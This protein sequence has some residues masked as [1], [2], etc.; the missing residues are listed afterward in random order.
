MKGWTLNNPHAALTPCSSLCIQFVRF[1]LWHPGS[2]IKCWRHLHFVPN[3]FNG[4]FCTVLVMSWFMLGWLWMM[5]WKWYGRKVVVAY[6]EVVSQK[7]LGQSEESY[8]KPQFSWAERVQYLYNVKW[9]CELS[10]CEVWIWYVT[11]CLTFQRPRFK[12][13]RTFQ[14]PSVKCQD[15]CH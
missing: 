11:A 14:Q 10:C 5:H 9:E 7:F 8:T 4:M 3:I 12:W 13:F 1:S 2:G 15:H 6:F